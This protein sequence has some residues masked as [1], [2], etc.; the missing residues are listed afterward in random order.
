[1]GVHL[2]GGIVGSI[3]LGVFAQYS[4]NPDG[5]TGSG[6]RHIQGLVYG[7]V[8][9]FLTQ[10]LAVLAVLAFSF[11]SSYV[12]ALVIDRLVGLRA[13]EEQEFTGLDISLH[14][15]QAYVLTE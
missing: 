7:G 13:T 14:E 6:G 11:V 12:L 1:M 2:I 5:L 10:I 8:G 3:L 4:I 15:E 9:F